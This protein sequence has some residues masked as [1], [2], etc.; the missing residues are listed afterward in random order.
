MDHSLQ[1]FDTNFIDVYHMCQSDRLYIINL[2]SFWKGRNTYD[3]LIP[4]LS[5]Y[6]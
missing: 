4:I 5:K 1:N 6:I 2:F 3:E